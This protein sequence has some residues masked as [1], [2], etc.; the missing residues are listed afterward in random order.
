M[1]DTFAAREARWRGVVSSALA[2]THGVEPSARYGFAG[3]VVAEISRPGVECAH[4]RCAAKQPGCPHGAFAYRRISRPAWRG[5]GSA[6][7]H[8]IGRNHGA[9]EPYPERGADG[10]FGVLRRFA[11]CLMAGGSFWRA[12]TARERCRCGPLAN[13]G[14][15]SRRASFTRCGCGHGLRRA[16]FGGGATFC[17]AAQPRDAGRD[18]EA[19]TVARAGGH[20]Q[21]TGYAAIHQHSGA[22]AGFH[23]CAEAD[24]FADEKPTRPAIGADSRFAGC[25]ALGGPRGSADEQGD[26]YR[27]SGRYFAPASGCSR[28]G[29]GRGGCICED[30]GGGA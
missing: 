24:D 10:E 9:R 27:D 3:G 17:G 11:R 25:A 20:G 14:G 4:R 23:P 7:S 1:C 6:F 18:G 16:A 28:G 29:A 2:G 5:G 8:A 30:D 22:G 21:R 15:V 26:G 13:R 19:D 12:A